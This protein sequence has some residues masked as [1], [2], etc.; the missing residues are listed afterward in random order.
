MK[1]YTFR[2]SPHPHREYL[3]YLPIPMKVYE[4]ALRP[5]AKTDKMRYVILMD[6]FFERQDNRE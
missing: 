1:E 3:E 4:K 6:D 5:E 2:R